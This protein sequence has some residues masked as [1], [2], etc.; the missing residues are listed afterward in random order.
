[1]DEGKSVGVIVSCVLDGG[2][3]SSCKVDKENVRLVAVASEV[4]LSVVVAFSMPDVLL[5]VLVVVGFE[6]SVVILLWFVD[7]RN[8]FKK[9]KP[10]IENFCI[11]KEILYVSKRL[12]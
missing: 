6:I 5:L 9:H 7:T 11:C 10:S 8:K 12:N 4:S 2:T 1:M 3:E